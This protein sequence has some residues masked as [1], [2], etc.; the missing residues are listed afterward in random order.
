MRPSA[1]A[2]SRASAKRSPAWAVPVLPTVPVRSSAKA[3]VFA[4]IPAAARLLARPWGPTRVHVRER[5]RGDAGLLERLGD[6]RLGERDVCVLAEAL[7][8][9]PRG[10]VARHAPALQ[11]LRGGRR[12]AHRLRQGGGGRI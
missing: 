6:G 9:L 12:G 7:L 10:G 4:P 3:A 5:L 11:E 8:P 2:R 1:W